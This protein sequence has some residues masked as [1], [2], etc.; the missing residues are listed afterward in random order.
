MSVYEELADRFEDDELPVIT[1]F[2]SKWIGNGIGRRGHRSPPYFPLKMWNVVGRHEQGITR[3]NNAIEAFNDKFS[4]LLSCHHSSVWTLINSIIN[5]R[6]NTHAHIS[7]GDIK[8]PSEKEASRNARIT[9]IIQYYISSNPD[10]TLRGI[11]LIIY[12]Y[13]FILNFLLN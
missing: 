13:N 7:R 4:S 9:N 6:E 5:L 12:K 8:Q 2:E 1:Y 10:M 3:T 11:L